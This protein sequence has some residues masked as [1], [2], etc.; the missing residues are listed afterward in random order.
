[1][2]SGNHTDDDTNA[3]AGYVLADSLNSPEGFDMKNIFGGQTGVG[4]LDTIGGGG[5]H[6]HGNHHGGHAH[7]LSSGAMSMEGVETS[8]GQPFGLGSMGASGMMGMGMGMG[9]GGLGSSGGPASSTSSGTLMQGSHHHNNNNNN[10]MLGSNNGNGNN[11][12]GLGV[13][14]M[15]TDKTSPSTGSGEGDEGEDDDLPRG[16]RTTRSLKQEDEPPVL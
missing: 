13:S 15:M 8:S 11:G 6:G 4:P 1:M 10:M 5:V 9:L 7:T 14:V 12:G 16:R 3:M 2:Q